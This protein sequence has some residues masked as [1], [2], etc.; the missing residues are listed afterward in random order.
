[1][2]AIRTL[3]AAAAALLLT[4]AACAS[5]RS[6]GTGT[7]VLS[8]RQRDEPLTVQVSN[9]NW[10]TMAVYVVSGGMR[11]RIGEVNSMRTETL[12]VPRSAMYADGTVRLA[13]DPIGQDAQFVTQPIRVGQGQMVRLDVE[14]M[15]PTSS[16]AVLNL[17]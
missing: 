4:T 1:M 16:F 15:L 12:R 2:N 13:L 17:R 8:A 10:A 11:R 9:R 3:C 14:Q 5:S 7:E 6:A